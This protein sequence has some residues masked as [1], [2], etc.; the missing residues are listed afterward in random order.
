MTE[1]G[2]ARFRWALGHLPTGVTVIT[3]TG[4]LGQPVG[5]ACNSFTSV[6]L[7][8]PLVLF[9]PAKSSST[10]PLIRDRGMFCVNILGSGHEWMSRQFS[11]P[12]AD[13]FSGV[14]WSGSD[15]GPELGDAA[16]RISCAVTAEH[17]AG[18]HIIVVARVVGLAVAPGAAPLVFHRG[19][20]GSFTEIPESAE[21]TG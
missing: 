1:I 5:M 9:C 7:D 12:R 10:W 18:D 14:R 17:D 19:R 8:P 4:P 20:Y 2:E 16:A 6:S 11:A 15:S 21:V 3:S 13:R